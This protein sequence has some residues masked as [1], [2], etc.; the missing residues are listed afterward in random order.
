[1]KT[2]STFLLFNLLTIC[3]S[4]QVYQWR[5]PDRSGIFEE[6]NLLKEWPEEGPELLLELEGIGK[7]WSSPVVTADRVF[8]SGMKDST[9]YL[10]CIDFEGNIVW[11]KPYGSSWAKS[12]P[13]TRG[14]ATIEDDRVYILSGQGNLI[15]FDYENGDTKWEVNVDQVYGAEWHRWGVSE[16]I[17]IVDDKVICTPAG[18][19]TSVIALDKMSGELVWKTESTG[20]MRSYASPIIYE[21]NGLRYIIAVTGSYLLAVTPDDGKIVWKYEYHDEALWPRQ[22]GLIWT[23]TPVFQDN[24]FWVSK[25]YN[26]PSVMLEMDS[27]GQSIKEKFVDHTFDNHHHGQILI[28]GN[29]YGSNWLNNGKGKWLC[30]NWERGEIVW[31]EG[32]EN[33]GSIIYADGLFYLY[34]EKRGNVALVNPNK[35]EFDLISSFK[36]SKG[37]GPHWS[38]PYIAHG[39]LWLRHGDWMGVYLIRKNSN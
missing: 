32:W 5:G 10:S 26:Y 14:S 11:Q 22:G 2:L 36:V 12:F 39:K 6:T 18:D 15:C 35:N 25:G 4:A 1:M 3:A 34:E 20:G 16:S 21:W 37:S 7:G 31:I 17:L 38:H 27:T 33:K 8:V 28:D 13:D 24:H 9:D 30:M 19:Q 29:L 23:N